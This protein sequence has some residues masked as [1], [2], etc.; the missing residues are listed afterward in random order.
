MT[1]VALTGLD[2]VGP[3]SMRAKDEQIGDLLIETP[4][5]M[6]GAFWFW[7]EY[8]VCEAVRSFELVGY[9]RAAFGRECRHL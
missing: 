6:P 9:V 2:H 4:W 8:W 3:T 7:D 5:I 1:F